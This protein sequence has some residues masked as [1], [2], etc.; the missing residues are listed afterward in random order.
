MKNF[1]LFVFDCM[2]LMF[3]NFSLFANLADDDACYRRFK[4]HLKGLLN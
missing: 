4:I 2:M 3:V 1:E